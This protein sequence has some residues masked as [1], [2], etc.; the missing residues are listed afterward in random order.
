[1]TYDLANYR[2]KRMLHDMISNLRSMLK[3]YR[4]SSGIQVITTLPAESDFIDI[5]ALEK[6][7]ANIVSHYES[8]DSASYSPTFVVGIISKIESFNQMFQYNCNCSEVN[9]GMTYYAKVNSKRVK[10]CKCRV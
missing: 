4:N 10:N 7:I 3:L 6:E 2:D 8:D 1:M 5:L 9:G